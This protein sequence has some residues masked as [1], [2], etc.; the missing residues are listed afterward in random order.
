MAKTQK[1]S[2]H[3]FPQVRIPRKVMLFGDELAR[4]LKKLRPRERFP[5]GVVIRLAFEALHNHIAE[6]R[7]KKRRRR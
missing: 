1:D 2:N 7:S 3:D 6:E 4:E 5:R